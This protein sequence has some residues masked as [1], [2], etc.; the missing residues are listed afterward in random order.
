MKQLQAFAALLIQNFVV[1]HDFYSLKVCT[2]SSFKITEI[3][4]IYT[5]LFYRAL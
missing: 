1:F 3:F 4:D 2:Q 5:H